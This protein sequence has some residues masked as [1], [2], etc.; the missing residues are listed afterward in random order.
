MSAKSGWL[1][2]IVLFICG[3]Q[4]ESKTLYSLD[5]DDTGNFCFILRINSHFSKWVYIYIC[6]HVLLI[7]FKYKTSICKEIPL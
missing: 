2:L 5:A 4:L 6:I 1:F 3:G 7:F